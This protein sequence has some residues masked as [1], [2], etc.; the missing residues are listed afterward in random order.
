VSVLVSVGFVLLCIWL[1]EYA[2]CADANKPM[3]TGNCIALHFDAL[4]CNQPRTDYES[5]ALTVE[6][7]D[8]DQNSLKKPIEGILGSCDNEVLAEVKS[9]SPYRRFVIALHSPNGVVGN[10]TACVPPGEN[11]TKGCVQGSV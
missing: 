10:R 9:L 11:R 1:R 8:D 5:A 3:N 4:H 6:L 7:Q 2:G